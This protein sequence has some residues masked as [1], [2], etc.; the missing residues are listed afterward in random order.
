MG[1]LAPLGLVLDYEQIEAARP[2]I[3][4]LLRP[5]AEDLEGIAYAPLSGE[6][7]RLRCD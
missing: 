7:W 1:S 3:A 5:R 4:D 2:V 6:G